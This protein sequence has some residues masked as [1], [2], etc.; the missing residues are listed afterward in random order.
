MANMDMKMEI[1]PTM[2]V[3]KDPDF[4][5][6]RP[7]LSRFDGLSL[8]ANVRSSRVQYS[9]ASSIETVLEMSAR[10]SAGTDVRRLLA[11]IF[12]TKYG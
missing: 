2:P 1:K 3:P 10:H 4:D 11:G 7:F 8:S 5:R 12:Q 9:N 6:L